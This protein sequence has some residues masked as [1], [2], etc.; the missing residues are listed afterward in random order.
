MAYF[1]TASIPCV[2]SNAYIR[3]PPIDLTLYI[4]RLY[5]KIRH[6]KLFS[7]LRLYRNYRDYPNTPEQW[8]TQFIVQKTWFIVLAL[9]EFHVHWQHHSPSLG[10]KVEHEHILNLISLLIWDDDLDQLFMIIMKFICNNTFT[11]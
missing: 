5:H 11:S 2:D 6:I 3:L 10:K 4:R 9:L 7:S 1:V 8:V